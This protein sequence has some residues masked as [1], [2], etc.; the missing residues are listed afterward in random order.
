MTTF[1]PGRRLDDNVQVLLR[2]A[3][4]AR[5]MLWSSQV[6]PGNENGLRLRVYGAKG[7]LEWR[8]DEWRQDEPN[9]L[10]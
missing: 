6:A 8:Q 2:Y 10:V 7:G 1:V 3:N 5:G 4:S 9:Y